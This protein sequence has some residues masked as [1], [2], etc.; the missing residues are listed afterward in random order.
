VRKNI[1]KHAFVV[2]TVAFALGLVTGVVS[3]SHSPAAKGWLISHLTGIM[4]ALLMSVVGLLWSDLQLGARAARV[5]YWSTV[6]A[7][8]LVMLLL[9]ILAPA[10]GGLPPLAVPEAPPASP[11]ASLVVTSGIILATVSSFVM[12]GLVL[13]GLRSTDRPAPSR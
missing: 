8:Y 1:L 12:A 2:L 10:L 3:G 4:V 11:V 6:P 5:L 13:Y 9:G 7:N